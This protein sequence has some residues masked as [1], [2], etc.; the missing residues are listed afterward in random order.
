MMK[1]KQEEIFYLV[2][3]YPSEFDFD[4][5]YKTLKKIGVTYNEIFLVDLYHRYAAIDIPL[6]VETIAA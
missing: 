4:K 6:R 2:Q 1:S 5:I 3:N